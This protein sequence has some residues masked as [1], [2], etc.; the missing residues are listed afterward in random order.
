MRDMNVY[1]GA[2]NTHSSTNLCNTQEQKKYHL[3]CNKHLLLLHDGMNCT[4]VADKLKKR[5]DIKLCIQ[6]ALSFSL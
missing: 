6:N 5:K 1:W 3:E 4:T 2:S